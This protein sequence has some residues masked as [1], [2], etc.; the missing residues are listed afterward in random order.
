[1]KKVGIA[2]TVKLQPVTIDDLAS[3]RYVHKASFDSIAGVQHSDEEVQAQVDLIYSRNYVDVIL[4]NNTYCAWIGD[5][6]IGTSGWCPA[7]GRRSIARIN[8]ISVH[9]L[10]HD[11]G[12]GRMLVANA[13]KRAQNAGFYEFSVRS[14]TTAIPFYKRQGYHV[15]SH[16]IIQTPKRVD[17]PVAFMRK[18]NIAEQHHNYSQQMSVPLRQ[19]A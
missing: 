3:I 15:S 7:D 16:G 6:I 17:L 4:S 14:V 19:T 5:E 9:P 18:H 10:F 13:E 1:M 2:D 12:I 11:L 8:M